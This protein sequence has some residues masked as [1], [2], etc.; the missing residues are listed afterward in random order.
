MIKAPTPPA[1]DRIATLVTDNPDGTVSI[2]LGGALVSSIPCAPSYWPRIPG[3]RVNVSIPMPGLMRVTGV[4]SGPPGGGGSVMYAAPSAPYQL[5][6]STYVDASTGRVR[7]VVP[8]PTQPTAGSTGK[9]GVLTVPSSALRTYRGSATMS[10]T[11]ARQG[12]WYG[13][14]PD[15]GVALYAAASVAPL[16]GKVLTSLAVVAHRID[17]GGVIGAQPVAIGVHSLTSMPASAPTLSGVDIKG[18]LA[19]NE[20]SASAPWP[21]PTAWASTI[22]SGGGIGVA[23]DAWVELDQLDLLIGWSD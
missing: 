13:Y 19:R 23:G 20:S 8:A 7:Y 21:L 1:Q 2:N 22:R 9:S 3:D 12:T 18:Y 10:D 17:G 5:A 16:A 15:T 6:S 14:G 11:T 4:C